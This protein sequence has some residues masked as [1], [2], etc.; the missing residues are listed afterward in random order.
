M[1]QLREEGWIHHVARNATACFLTRGDLWVCWE[2]G[3]KVSLSPETADIIPNRRSIPLKGVFKLTLN[4][5]GRFKK[6]GQ[7]AC[8]MVDRQLQHTRVMRVVYTRFG[9]RLESAI[10]SVLPRFRPFLLPSFLLYTD[11]LQT[12]PPLHQV[13]N[14]VLEIFFFV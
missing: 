5:F 14:F 7:S 1:I 2:E 8:G 6:N 12:T 11:T 13:R 4:D 9:G 10:R 3:M